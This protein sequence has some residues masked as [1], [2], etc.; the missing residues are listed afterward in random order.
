MPCTLGGVDETIGQRIKRIAKDKGKPGG[1]K[2]AAA[3]GVSYEALRRWSKGIDH[4]SPANAKVIAEFLGVSV[5][6]VLFGADPPPRQ[7]DAEALADAFDALPV[8]TAHAL[9]RRMW[10]YTSLM[11]QIAAHG[12]TAA[13]APAPGPAEQPTAAPSPGQ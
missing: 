5:A 4:P 12:A 9:E 13:S 8:D 7:P 11:S 2:L 6:T 1:E 10:L 3:L